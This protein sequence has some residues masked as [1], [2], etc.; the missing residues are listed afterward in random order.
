MPGQICKKVKSRRG[1]ELAALEQELREDYFR[2]L[3]GQ[4]L[5]VLI[6]NVD[7]DGVAT[8][9]SGHY[10]PVSIAN[11]GLALRR[12]RL[13]NVEARTTDGKTIFA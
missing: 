13:V 2:G 8:G 7:D 9:T 12:G 11:S 10:A 3:V 1:R 4:Q 5:Q 6:E